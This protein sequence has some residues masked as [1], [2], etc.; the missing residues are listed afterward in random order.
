MDDE[1]RARNRARQ[2]ARRARLREQGLSARGR[3]LETPP[4]THH[5]SHAPDGAAQAEIAA[6]RAEVARLKAEAAKAARAAPRATVAGLSGAPFLKASEALLLK[7][8][9]HPNGQLSDEAAARAWA[10]W[11]EKVLPLFKVIPD[12]VVAKRDARDA[13]LTAR[14]KDG[15]AALDAKRAAQA[16]AAKAKRA[17]AKA[18]KGET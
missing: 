15:A 17:A 4:V 14:F 16:A 1:T 3:P 7:K 8:A 2:A 11:T 12:E 6:L 13:A 5:A 18:A 10:I 9:M